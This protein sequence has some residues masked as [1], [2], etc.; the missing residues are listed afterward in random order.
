MFSITQIRLQRYNEASVMDDVDLLAV[1]EPM[2]IRLGFGPEGERE[3]R[4]LAITMRTPGH[5][6]ELALGFAFSENIIRSMD[7]VI[8]VVYCHD[9]GRQQ[10]DNIVRIELKPG[11]TPDWQKLQRHVYTTS[12]CGVCGKT[13]I[14]SVQKHC[15]KLEDSYTIPAQRISNLH[16]EMQAAQ[17]VFAHTGGLH[18][19]ALF[20]SAGDLK[21][22][23]EDVGRHNA[24]DKVVGAML[25]QHQLPLSDYLLLVSGRASFELVQKAAMAG[26]PMV[27]AVGAPS[28]LAVQLAR[29]CN[30]TLVG[31]ARNHKFNVY[32]GGHRIR[33]HE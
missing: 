6:F 13:S 1:E 14:E 10:G 16:Q 32:S 2:E 19:S 9:A 28:S 7:D 30:M 26:I 33:L 29:E 31:F 17:P 27:V 15:S 3:Q 21:L 20:N 22:L 5:D 12:S 18:A 23:R 8:H 11:C 4:S 24:L 25:L